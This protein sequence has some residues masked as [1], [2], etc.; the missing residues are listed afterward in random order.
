MQYVKD[1]IVKAI[2]DLKANGVGEELLSNTKSNLKYGFAMR[3]DNPDAVANTL[4]HYIALTGDPETVN[5]I[6]ALYEKITVEDVKKIAA[7]YFYPG[8]PHD[9]NHLRRRGRGCP[10]KTLMLAMALAYAIPA[11]GQEVVELKLPQSSKVVVKL[12]F[13]NGSIC[14][15][16]GREGL[17]YLTASLVAQGGTAAMTF[18]QIQ[19]AIYPMAA[20]YGVSVDKEVCVFTFEVHRD[21]LTKFYPILRGL[22][23]T[24]SFTDQ[25]FQRIKVNQQTYVDQ[26]IRASSDEEYSKMAL[27]DLLFRGTNYQHMKQGTSAGVKAITPDDV[28]KHY[29]AFFTCANL[30]IG[31]AGGYDDAF[32]K[33]LKDDMAKLPGNETG[34]S[35]AGDRANPDRHRCGDC[36]QRRCVRFSDLHRHTTQPDACRRRFSG[37]DGGPFYLGE[38]RKS[39]S[40]LYHEIRANRSMNYGDYS[41]IEWYENGGGNMLPQPGVPRTSSY[42]P[43]WIRPVQIAA[44]LRKQYPELAEVKSA[45][46][47]LHSGWP[48]TNSACSFRRG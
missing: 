3:I 14:D 32:L 33:M 6:Y 19:D 37:V 28:R 27:E 24:P 4:C 8:R 12:M 26:L 39:Y 34:H 11:L 41:Y 2:E 36:G 48:F 47:T 20:N 29:T 25:D 35:E 5:R 43:I 18:S 42:F 44:Q 10:M 13:R 21:W 30:M 9:R 22:I 45:T 16:K 40:K 7:R 15:P 31:V 17:T 1:E 23:L 46:P 38:H